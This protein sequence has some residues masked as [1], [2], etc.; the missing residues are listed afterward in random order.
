MRPVL[1]PGKH[2]SCWK[3]RKL[4]PLPALLT[5]FRVEQLNSLSTPRIGVI[6]LF[7]ILVRPPPLKKDLAVQQDL[8]SHIKF[9][10]ESNSFTIECVHYITNLPCIELCCNE[11][12]WDALS[13]PFHWNGI[14]CSFSICHHNGLVGDEEDGGDGGDA[15][16]EP[17]LQPPCAPQQL[18]PGSWP[19]PP[20]W[21]KTFNVSSGKVSLLTQPQIIFCT[22]RTP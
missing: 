2:G 3:T 1:N 9:Q 17:G 5:I 22:F 10:V 6:Q 12:Y 18:P 13:K 4:G 11:M 7:P 15:T 21:K 16:S 8:L 19:Q 20:P 14:S